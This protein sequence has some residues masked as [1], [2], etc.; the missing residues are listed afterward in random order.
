MIQDG[1]SQIR[2]AWWIIVT[3]R[4]L[5]TKKKARVKKSTPSFTEE[6]RNRLEIRPERKM[7]VFMEITL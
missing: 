1:K 5:L 4:V 2:M 6:T 3:G 7:N